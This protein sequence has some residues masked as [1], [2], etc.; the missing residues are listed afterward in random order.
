M[1]LLV[2]F[3]SPLKK[4][5]DPLENVEN[6]QKRLERIR[7]LFQQ[8]LR[9]IC[10]G[11]LAIG[12]SISLI[13]CA[14]FSETRAL[15]A[16]SDALQE[17]DLD[18]LKASTSGRFK[19]KSLRL[20]SSVDDFAVL[21]L[22]K[23]DIEI[24]D[25]NKVSK[26]EKRV[27][28]KVGKSTQRLKYR[29]VREP[30]SRKWVVD[31]VFLRRK[32][33]GVVS[34]KPITELM[35]LVTTV[36]EFLGAWDHGIRDDMLE[37]STP[38]L[39]ELLASLP[40]AYLTRLAQQAIGDRAKDSRLR[41]EA[42]LD[43]D[44]AVV[45]LPRTS[46]QMILSFEKIDG[47]WLVSDMAVESRKDKDHIT[48][49]RQLATVL[50]SA[51]TFLDAYRAGDKAKLKTVTRKSFYEGSIEPAQLK[52]VTLP[53]SRD[54][55]SEYEV[56]LTNGI[57]DFVVPYRDEL[58]KL[59]L[60][61]VE[62][63][64]ADSAI[65][66]RVDE[67]TIYELT[68]KQ[69]KRL[70]ALFLSHAMMQIYSQAL[71][72]GDLDTLTINATTDFQ[73]R[74]W[75]KIDRKKPADRSLLLDLKLKEIEV[76]APK[77]LTTSFMGAVTEVTV[78]QGSRAL[79]YVLRDHK[80][81]LQVD[82]ILIPVAGR[83]NSLKQHYETMIPVYRF[84][85]AIVS[86]DMATLHRTSSRD[87][88]RAVWHQT[89]RVPSVGVNYADFFSM[90]LST[91]KFKDDQAAMFLGDSRFGARVLLIREGDAYVVDD[92]LLITGPEM[93]QRIELKDALRLEVR[94]IQMPTQKKRAA[95]ISV[96]N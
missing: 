85:R 15:T 59:S 44:V 5:S 73:Q 55:A 95:K 22:P 63:A 40:P 41:P 1:N 6:K 79:V 91:L 82:D 9:Q 70:S 93:R 21:R 60:T 19:E 89:K 2:A 65:Q 90:P 62:G 66:Y 25:V 52:V 49:V 46:G 4:G 92:V 75:N 69:E 20:A 45:R 71:V 28:V 61:K 47:R 80:G 24:T 42:H 64:D 23:G 88:N 18:D 26:N 48:S 86:D 37:L 87:F 77:I 54:A 27:T 57:A 94:H 83:P 10:G 17:K 35:D 33:D 51:A 14:N 39:G 30:G 16:F 31:D 58:V 7:P 56:K 34:T 96:G 38:D 72:T 43:D 32:K 36:R 12:A 3:S 67:V 74:V 76:A 81:Q 84:A 29:L 8:A 50:N 78:R 68:G 53:T 13:G 11:L